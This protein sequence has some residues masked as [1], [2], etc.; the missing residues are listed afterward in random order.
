MRVLARYSSRSV[1]RVSPRAVV[2]SSVSR[3]YTYLNAANSQ[4]F[5]LPSVISLSGDFAISVLVYYPTAV[6][7]IVCGYFSNP[8]QI[9][10]AVNNTGT[11]RLKIAGFELDSAVGIFDRSRLNKITVTRIGGNISISLN[12]IVVATG[13]NTGGFSFSKI[14][15]W[16]ALLYHS[17][18]IIADFNVWS[19]TADVLS[20]PTY[21][22]AIDSDGAGTT[23]SAT[24][25]DIPLTRVNL[26]A[27]STEAYT[28]NAT[29]VSWIGVAN[30]LN[31]TNWPGSL[32]PWYKLNTGTY[33]LFDKSVQLTS[34]TAYFGVRQNIDTFMCSIIRFEYIDNGFINSGV[35]NFTNTNGENITPFVTARFSSGAYELPV[36]S[37]SAINTISL[38]V[39]DIGATG[40]FVNPKIYNVIP[41][42]YTT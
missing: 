38:R 40:V 37:S 25:G 21:S 33:S 8:L 11:I 5:N 20:A 32:S 26:T 23:E 41:A 10:L 19:G 30:K 36:I 28:Y 1:A 29:S 39:Q 42:G 16:D 9:F 15:S 31:T 14:G 34:A 13:I 7:N 12:G 3:Y 35:V 17:T 22:W 18:G 24:I 4:Y 6:I 27:A 2:S